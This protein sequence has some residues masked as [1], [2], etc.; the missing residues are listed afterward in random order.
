MVAEKCLEVE[1]NHQS[2]LLNLAYHPIFVS[3]LIL[4]VVLEPCHPNRCRLAKPILRIY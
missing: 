1:T 4:P 3:K 2:E